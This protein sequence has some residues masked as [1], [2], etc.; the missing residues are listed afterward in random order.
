MQREE[1]RRFQP[2]DR[3]RLSHLRLGGGEGG[4]QPE[5]IVLRHIG[6]IDQFFWEKHGWSCMEKKPGQ[7]ESTGENAKKAKPLSSKR[8]SEGGSDD[9]CK[10]EKGTG[11][12]GWKPGQGEVEG[13]AAERRP[14][15]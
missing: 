7:K 5:D 9:W 12:S 15:R 14:T 8:E 13:R 10:A 11:V 2:P 3:P 1:K 6:C 4:C